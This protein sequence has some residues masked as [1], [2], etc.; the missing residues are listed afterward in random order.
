M[1]LVKHIHYMETM[2]TS[3]WG[4]SVDKINLWEFAPY[5][6]EYTFNIRL[7]AEVED[8]AEV[9]LGLSNRIQLFN[10]VKKGGS[11]VVNSYDPLNRNPWFGKVVYIGRGIREKSTI[12]EIIRRRR[13]NVQL[14]NNNAKYAS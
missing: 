6:E 4:P 5:F 12:R 14:C 8:M 2:N 10:N 13:A 1:S 7:D 9:T 11:L 3:N